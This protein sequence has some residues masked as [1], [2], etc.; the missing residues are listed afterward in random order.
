ME[1]KTTPLRTRVLNL[2]APAVLIVMTIVHIR[3]YRH[4]VPGFSD[5]L[6]IAICSYTVIAGLIDVAADLY[7]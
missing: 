1:Q 7:V 6:V 4:G 3:L 5:L 2:L